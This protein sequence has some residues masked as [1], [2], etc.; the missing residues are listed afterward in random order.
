MKRFLID[1]LI[2]TGLL[3]FILGTF[4]TFLKVGQ[5][6][7]QRRPNVKLLK[8]L[9]LHEVDPEILILGSSIAEAGFNSD[10][11]EIITGKK[12]FNAALSGRK[13]AD[14]R[15]VPYQI[16]EYGENTEVVILDVFINMFDWYSEIYNPQDYYPYLFNSYVGSTLSEINNQLSRATKV[17]FYELTML[18]SNYIFNAINSWSTGLKK[19]HSGFLDY[20]RNSGSDFNPK[21][22]KHFV[23][24]Q[25]DLSSEQAYYMLIHEYKIRN[26]KVYFVAPPLYFEAQEILEN[27]P[28]VINLVKSIADSTGSEFLDYS[29]HKEFIYNKSFFFNNTHLNKTGAD[30]F[31][32]MLAKQLKE[33][34]TSKK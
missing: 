27:Y 30:L 3:L 21:S 20:T 13:I 19:D 2:L 16:L 11:I 8:V 22:L 34:Y 7:A 26:I 31:S 12:T 5:K 28:E 6:F 24:P 25:I 32:V 1:L 23:P 9:E 14:W 18:N 15:P 33:D 17:P 29:N 4:S 10:S